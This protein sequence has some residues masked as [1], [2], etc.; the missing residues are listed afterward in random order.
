VGA[1]EQRPCDGGGTQG[2]SCD[3]CAWSPWSICQP[4]GQGGD[5]PGGTGGAGPGETSIPAYASAV[6]GA[7]CSLARVGGVGGGSPLGWLGLA[8]ALGWRRRR[9]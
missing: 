2:R 4:G 8:L 1:E 5:A 3:G 9:G 7:V 6:Q